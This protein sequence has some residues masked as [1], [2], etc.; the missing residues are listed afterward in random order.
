MME[1]QNKA[2]S[3]STL[4]HLTNLQDEMNRRFGEVKDAMVYRRP[5]RYRHRTIGP[6]RQG[7]LRLVMLV[8]VAVPLHVHRF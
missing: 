1:E 8:H 7:A 2:D 6:G 4:Y 5:D 3:E